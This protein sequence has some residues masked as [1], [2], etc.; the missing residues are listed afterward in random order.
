MAWYEHLFGILAIVVCVGGGFSAIL[1][2]CA[3]YLG[4]KS[5]YHIKEKEWW[6]G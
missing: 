5:D 4:G 2:Y 6:D 3:V 1:T